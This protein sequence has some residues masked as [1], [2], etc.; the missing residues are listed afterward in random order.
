MR[1]FWEEKKPFAEKVYL[2]EKRFLPPSPDGTF[3]C[4]LCKSMF[5]VFEALLMHVGAHKLYWPFT[6]IREPSN[7]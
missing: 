2:L 1:V 5:L 3:D 6:S 4:Y 7:P